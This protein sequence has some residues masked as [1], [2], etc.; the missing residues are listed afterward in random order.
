MRKVYVIYYI[1][2]TK[3]GYSLRPAF[4]NK[5]APCID[6]WLE[7]PTFGTGEE[8]CMGIGATLVVGAML[9]SVS[10]DE[11][12]TLVVACMIIFG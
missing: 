8:V 3:C 11:V 12:T 2:T 5:N 9:V 4:I 10:L 6:V 7:R 1:T